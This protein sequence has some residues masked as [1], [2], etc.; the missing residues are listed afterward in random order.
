VGTD[1][2]TKEQLL[3][4]LELANRRI[5]ELENLADKALQKY[6]DLFHIHFSLSND[7]M[8]SFDNKYN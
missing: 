6:D 1:N 8:Y 5:S 3:A 2:R 4:E 7:V